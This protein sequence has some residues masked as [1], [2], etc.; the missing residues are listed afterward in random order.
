MNL[1]ELGSPSGGPTRCAIGLDIGGTKIAGGVVTEAG[2]TTQVLRIPTPRE[3]GADAMLQALMKVIDRLRDRT[4]GIEAIGVGAAGMVEWPTGL[5]RCAPNNAYDELPLQDLLTERTGLPIT[6]ENDANA[7]AWAEWRFGQGANY[8]NGLLLTIGTGIGGGIIL[9]DQLYR[10][11]VGIGSEVG[12]IVINPEHGSLCGCGVTGCLEAQASGTALGR[13]G[14][15]AAAA[16]P[17][18][19]LASLH[20]GPGSVTGETV[21]SAAEHGDPTARALFDKLGYW[22][23]AGIASLVNIFNP[24]IV[25][26]GGGLVTTR[27]YLFPPTQ[28]SFEQFVFAGS[29]RKLPL[30]E[31][32]R[33]G[34]EAGLVGAA[35][36]AL[37]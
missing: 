6:V 1:N 10:G 25:L 8:R 23:G 29:Q 20:G 22:L 5:I 7:A 14:R 12:H 30:I 36:L 17:T 26:I 32:A 3:G 19:L 33:L 37:K 31:C 35:A 34:A 13:M 28:A 16:D 11:D 4:P 9:N 15:E 24:E 21:F 27:Q 18:G 2:E